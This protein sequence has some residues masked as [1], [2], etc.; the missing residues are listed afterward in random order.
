MR[1]KKRSFFEKLTGSIRMVDD[2]FDDF[3]EEEELEFDTEEAWSEDEEE[4]DGQLAVDVYQT[5]NAIVI[6][7]FIAGVKPSDLNISINR[8][9]VSIRGSRTD[10]HRA[11]TNDYFAQ[12]LYWGSFSRQITLPYEVDI[13]QADAYEERGLLTITLPKLD[14]DRET[15]LR[16][17]TTG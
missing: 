2:H 13:D 11:H 9:N 17:R 15:M 12:E 4:V 5:S 1:K 16:I 7:A 14:K 10:R 6:K 8:E 3:A